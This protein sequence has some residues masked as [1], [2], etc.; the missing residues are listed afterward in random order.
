MLPP[1]HSLYLLLSPA[2]RV[3]LLLSP[4]LSVYLSL[5]AQSIYRYVP[6]SSVLNVF[7]SFLADLKDNPLV[8]TT[9]IIY[10]SLPTAMNAYLSLSLF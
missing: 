4:A 8:P 10:M 1:A 6:L 9:L 2:L 5:P 3:C 7:L